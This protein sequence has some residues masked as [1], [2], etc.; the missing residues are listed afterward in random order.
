[1]PIRHCSRRI[2]WLFSIPMILIC[3][4]FVVLVFSR[5]SFLDSRHYLK[6]AL[7]TLDGNATL[8]AP[9]Y[10]DASFAS[11]RF[12]MVPSEVTRRVGSPLQRS[13]WIDSAGKLAGPV[14][15]YTMPKKPN[16]SYW[17]REVYFANGVVV[18]IISDFYLD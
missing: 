13:D 18:D 16:G 10:T 4:S 2:R 9:T 5:K 8:Y 11:L 6:Y 14:W 3:V 7:A 1:M 17:R 15:M 12:G